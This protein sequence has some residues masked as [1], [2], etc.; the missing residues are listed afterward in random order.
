MEDEMAI[1]TRYGPEVIITA[2][3]IL[4]IWRKVAPSKISLHIK[5]PTQPKRGKVT[6]EESPNWY[7][8]CHYAEGLEP[9]HNGKWT[10]P[11]WFVADDGAREI[12][13]LLVKLNPED[14]AK[15]YEWN[16]E[17]APDMLHFFAA[18]PEKDV[19]I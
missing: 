2:A 3:R 10:S 7:V 12:S 1:Y 6:I 5:K 8:K 14:S 19:E 16:K 15:W 17:G 9:I 4:P 11:W 18:L 13:D